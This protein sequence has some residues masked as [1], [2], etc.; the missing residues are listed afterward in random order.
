[1]TQVVLDLP[2]SLVTSLSDSFAEVSLRITDANGWINLPRHV[3]NGVIDNA[4]NSL[5]DVLDDI[6]EA[7]RE[8]RVEDPG[9]NEVPTNFRVFSVFGARVTADNP[10]ESELRIKCL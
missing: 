9:T 5:L 4:V 7:A 1:M 10:P 8:Y 2:P 6:R 3:M